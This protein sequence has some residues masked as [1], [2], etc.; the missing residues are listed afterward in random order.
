MKKYFILFAISLFL[1]ACGGIGSPISTTK[2][3]LTLLD[4]NNYAQACQSIINVQAQALSTKE[5]SKCEQFYEQ[6]FDDIESFSVQNAV[7]QSEGKLKQF[8]AT[9]G[10]EVYFSIRTTQG[11]DR[12]LKAFVVKN[13]NEWKV[14]YTD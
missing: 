9:E 14:V 13:N 11:H 10:F 6:E 5:V 7:L 4:N 3:F 8:N 2:D 12:N 1:T